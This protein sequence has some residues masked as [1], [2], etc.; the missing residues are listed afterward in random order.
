[1]ARLESKGFTA[2]FSVDQT[3]KEVFDAINDVRGWWSEEIE[4]ST[5]KQG[6]EFDYHYQDLHRRKMR[7]MEPDVAMKETGREFSGVTPTMWK[8]NSFPCRPSISTAA[9]ERWNA[10]WSKPRHEPL[11]GSWEGRTAGWYL[12]IFVTP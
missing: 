2:T 7:I 10:G 12:S 11:H 9:P 1:M 8:G 5:D 4:G 3:P 6:A